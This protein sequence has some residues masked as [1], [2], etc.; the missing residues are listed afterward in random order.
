MYIYW[1]IKYN[2]V[3]PNNNLLRHI[4]FFN[5]NKALHFLLSILL[6]S[7]FGFSQ[8]NFTNGGGDNLWS[9]AANWSGAV[10]NGGNAVVIIKSALVIVDGA[11]SVKQIK[12]PGVQPMVEEVYLQLL[13]MVSPSLYKLM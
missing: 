13:E 1:I 7:S 12:L 2:Q 11:Y 9:N 3:K 10:P 6:F 4:I 5:M 8:N